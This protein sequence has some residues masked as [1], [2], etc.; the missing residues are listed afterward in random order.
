MI[1]EYVKFVA[2]GDRIT[3]F[4]DITV[5]RFDGNCAVLFV[6]LS[7]NFFHNLKNKLMLQ[8]QQTKATSIQ[9][10]KKGYFSHSAVH[11]YVRSLIYLNTLIL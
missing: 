7:I 11:L 5:W 1:L 4:V 3:L 2:L 9:T 10:Q 8:T 6:V